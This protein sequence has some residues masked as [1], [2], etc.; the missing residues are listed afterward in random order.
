MTCVLFS[1]LTLPILMLSA[2]ALDDMGGANWDENAESIRLHVVEDPSAPP[3][4]PPTQQL[5]LGGEDGSDGETRRTGVLVYYRWRID[6][7][8]DSFEIMPPIEWPS[9]LTVGSDQSVVLDLGTTIPPAL[10]EMRLY[11]ELGPDGIPTDVPVILSCSNLEARSD[12]CDTR[13]PINGDIAANWELVVPLPADAGYYYLA[14]SVVW[15]DTSENAPKT[16]GSGHAAS[17]I[18][19]LRRL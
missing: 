9:P 7:R 19:A 17:W 14:T 12:G 15:V 13:R 4:R 11:G 6:G 16:E 5:I 2:C 3:E 10:V 1:A 8:T 18:F